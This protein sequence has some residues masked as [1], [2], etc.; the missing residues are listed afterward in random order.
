MTKKAQFLILASMLSF[1]IKAIAAINPKASFN[2]NQIV[3]LSLEVSENKKLAKADLVLPFFQTGEVQK[4]L[5][6]RSYL[7]E[8]SPRSGAKENEVLVEMKLRQ[9][10]TNIVI[11]QKSIQ[12]KLNE[13][14]VIKTHGLS[15]KLRPELI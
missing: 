6:D 8:L 2:T 15:I 9:A 14:T 3:N 1:S 12:A 5:G 13:N 10:K 7:I 4:N 11:M